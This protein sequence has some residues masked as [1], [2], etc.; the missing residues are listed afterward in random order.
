MDMREIQREL[1]SLRREIADLRARVGNPPVR[2]AKPAGDGR[3]LARLAGAE[4]LTGHA[5]RWRRA[6]VE[7]TLTWDGT[8][9]PATIADTPGGRTGNAIN[10]LE[11]AHAVEPAASAAWNVWGVQSHSGVSGSSYPSGFSP[12]PVPT[13]AVVTITPRVVAGVTI[14]TFE[15]MGSHDG[16]CG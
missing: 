11:F 8:L 4:L 12:Q 10:L 5:A 2:Y 3:F 6:F 13:G 14:Y 7:V 16:T 9:A 15:A 1:A